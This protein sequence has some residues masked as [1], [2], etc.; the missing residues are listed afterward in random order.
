MTILPL[1]PESLVHVEK[2]AGSYAGVGTTLAE[3]HDELF[4]YLRR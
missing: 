4:A 1:E 2:E 3:V